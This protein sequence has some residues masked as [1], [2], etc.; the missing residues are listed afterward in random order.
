[1][2]S[3]WSV[4]ETSSHLVQFEVEIKFNI[5][6]IVI[7]PAL[8]VAQSAVDDVAKAL[9]D[10]CENTQWWAADT[11][12]TLHLSVVNNTEIHML[13]HS[14]SDVVTSKWS[15]SCFPLGEFVRANSIQGV[16]K[17]TQTIEKNLLLEFQWPSTK[18]NV[19]SVKY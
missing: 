4:A 14:I 15:L 17:K 18:L 16:P 3:E 5:P 13:V 7:A 9:V 8:G 2:S 11:K 1:M 10:V 12:E 6:D 19:K